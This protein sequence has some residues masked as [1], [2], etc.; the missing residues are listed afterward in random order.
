MI[1]QPSPGCTVYVPPSTGAGSDVADEVLSTMPG[2]SSVSAV[3][4]LRRCSS[5]MD[6]PVRWAMIHQPS[7]GCT[8]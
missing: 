1:H 8:V 4:P 3:M 5:A 6:T 7:P 2:C